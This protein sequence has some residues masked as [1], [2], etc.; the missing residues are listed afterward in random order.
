MSSNK[1]APTPPSAEDSSS[2]SEPME[3][4]A[5]V[6]A[7]CLLFGAYTF[8]ACVRYRRRTRRAI[9][10]GRLETEQSRIKAERIMKQLNVFVSKNLKS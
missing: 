1:F 9:D 7:T 2:G 8:I 5:G 4:V 6:V 10:E 3:I